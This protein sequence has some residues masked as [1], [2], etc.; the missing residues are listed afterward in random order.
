MFPLAHSSRQTGIIYAEQLGFLIT[1]YN[2]PGS[3]FA[4]MTSEP[5]NYLVSVL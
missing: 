3:C 4:V 1:F 2:I 5:A